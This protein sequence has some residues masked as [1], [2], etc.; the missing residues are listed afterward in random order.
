MAYSIL[1]DILS[2]QQ[3]SQVGI[4]IET[5]IVTDILSLKDIYSEEITTLTKKISEILTFFDIYGIPPECPEIPAFDLKNLVSFTAKSMS[6]YLSN[7]L[8]K[9]EGYIAK[10]YIDLVYRARE[11]NTPYNLG[12]LLDKVK[13]D[14]KS[15][16]EEINPKIEN[17][18][19]NVVSEEKVESK[20]IKLYNE[21]NLYS[22]INSNFEITL[23]VIDKLTREPIDITGYTFTL[24]VKKNKKSSEI[25]YQYVK[26]A[27]EE[28]GSRNGQVPIVIDTNNLEPGEYYY[29]IT[30][31]DLIGSITTFMIGMLIVGES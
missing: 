18:I 31:V 12:Y 28:D 30:F 14:Y 7:S 29:D 15:F 6:S 16:L 13:N 23:H 1:T 25:S 11:E 26:V 3:I 22:P 2:L 4:R 9:F 20:T 17:A 21:V 8:E 27:E 24:T 10:L 19:W 5:L